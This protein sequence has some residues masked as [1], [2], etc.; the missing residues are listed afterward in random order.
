MR[1][2]LVYDRINK[3]GGAE[4][5]LLV[6][7]EMFPKAP[8]YTAVCD[9]EKAP[10]AKVFPKIK[11]SFLQNISFLKDKHELLGTFTP[12]AFE[13]LSSNGEF[14]KYDL[15]ISL[16]SEAAKGIITKPQTKHICICL[17]PTRYLWS[18][19]DLYFK[20]RILRFF[21]KRV[22]T[23]LRKWDIKASYR[24]D[25]M[26]AISTEVKKRIKKYYKRDS[27]V[28]FPPVNALPSSAEKTRNR[29]YY[30]VVSRLVSYKKLDLVVKAFKT[31]NKKLVIVGTGSQKWKYKLISK[32]RKNIEYKGTVGDKAL[33]RLYKNA[34]ALILPQE[35]DFGLVAVEAMSFGIPVIAFNKG[36]AKDIVVDGKTGV[37]FKSQT[38]DSL[39]AAIKKLE[40][41][42]F[43]S[44]TIMEHAKSFS[45][46]R[47]KDRLNEKIS[48]LF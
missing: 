3:W 28:I 38:T 20:N 48:K 43:N 23:H 11:T 17:T 9:L 6:F 4:R 1:T 15:V 37:F 10:W 12:I 18:H 21:S 27:T 16:T 32:F 7:H 31:L 46:K 42:S 25:E 35:E 29:D 19:Y 26:I 45:K 2:A 5:V 33:S 30:L 13:Q 22:V 40:K 44:D 8:L 39:L 14:D 36:G 47:F 41:M 24:P 34:V